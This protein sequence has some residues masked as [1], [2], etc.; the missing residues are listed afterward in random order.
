MKNA[1]V[2]DCVRTPIGRAHRERGYF[3][4][5]RSDDLAVVLRQR[6]DRADGNRSG[7]DRR[8]RVGQHS[9]DDGAGNQCRSHGGP[10]GRHLSRVRRCDDQPIV[11]QAAA[12]IESSVACDHGRL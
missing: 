5:V 11:R 3:R 7:C 2:V 10:D 6:P 1:V 9:A 8:C 12:G 4:H